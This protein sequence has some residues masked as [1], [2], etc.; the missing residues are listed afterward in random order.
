[1][2]SPGNAKVTPSEILEQ[3]ENHGSS[4]ISLD[5]IQTLLRSKDDTQRFVGLALLQSALSSSAELR[6]DHDAI[7][8]LWT[9]ISPKF[10]DRLLRT[11]AKSSTINADAKNML[12][13]AVAVIEAFVQLLPAEICGHARAFQRIPKLVEAILYR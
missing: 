2:G 1:M 4:Q 7:Q 12:E 6:A 11:G 3:N 9:S 5:K 8:A 10:L 13:L